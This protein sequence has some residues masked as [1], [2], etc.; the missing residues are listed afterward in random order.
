MSWPWSLKPMFWSGITKDIQLT[1]NQGATRRN[2]MQHI[3]NF[4][5]TVLLPIPSPVPSVP[6]KPIFTNFFDYHKYHCLVVAD[7]LSGW[8]A[9]FQAMHS[10]S[11]TQAG[12]LGATLGLA[13]LMADIRFETDQAEN[14]F[15]N[16]SIRFLRVAT[17]HIVELYKFERIYIFSPWGVKP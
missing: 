15:L 7:Q 4:T 1:R 2:H 13:E 14:I 11:T 17:I 9:I 12:V 5:H 10:H 8:V 6:F 3:C 16:I